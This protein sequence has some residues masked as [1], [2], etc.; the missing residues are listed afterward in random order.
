MVE[1]LRNKNAAT[2]F[3]ILVEIA[4]MQPNIQQRDIAKTLN[5]TPQAVSDYVK[6]LLKDGLL[7]S[8]GRSRYQVSTEE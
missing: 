8:R 3:Q 6:Q 5:V 1:I 4:A 7:I 2:R